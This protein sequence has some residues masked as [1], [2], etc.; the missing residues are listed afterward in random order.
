MLHDGWGELGMVLAAEQASPVLLSADEFTARL[1]AT[2]RGAAW[3]VE[4][5]NELGNRLFLAGANAHAAACYEFAARDDRAVGARVNLGRCEIRLGRV[6]L[7]ETRARRLIDHYPQRISG[8]QLLGEALFAQGRFDEAK[9]AAEH[10]LALS[11]GDAALAREWGRMAAWAKDSASAAKGFRLAWE[12]RPDDASSLGLSVFYS[13]CIYDWSELDALSARMLRM[14][15][16]EQALL[17]PFDLLAEPAT[18]AQQ[19]RCA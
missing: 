7:A 1:N 12:Q 10:A 14:L 6:T 11:G 17:P 2:M 15:D 16:D 3:D 5:L 9:G 19:A 4:T 18:A 8:W 13:R